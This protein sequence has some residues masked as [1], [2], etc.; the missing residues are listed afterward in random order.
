MVKRLIPMAEQKALTELIK[1]CKG[2]P[3]RAAMLGIGGQ[4]WKVVK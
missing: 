2:V 1:S 4:A 3:Q